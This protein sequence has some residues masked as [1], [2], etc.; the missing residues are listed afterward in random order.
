MRVCVWVCVYAHA[1][2]FE[3][4]TKIGQG[5]IYPQYGIDLIFLLI[6]HVRR[7]FNSIYPND[8]PRMMT[9]QTAKSKTIFQVNYS[10]TEII[11]ILQFPLLSLGQADHTPN[12]Y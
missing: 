2:M 6:S 7:K 3:R 1:A 10:A 5:R 11:K 4:M 12:K 9:M 8:P